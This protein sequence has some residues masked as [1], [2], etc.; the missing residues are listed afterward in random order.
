MLLAT[1]GITAF[2]TTR[3]VLVVFLDKPGHPDEHPDAAHGEHHELHKPGRLMMAPLAVDRI[4]GYRFVEAS[5]IFRVA[6]ISDAID[7]YIAK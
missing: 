7:R 2:Y 6:G 4:V 1:A 5:V 3:L